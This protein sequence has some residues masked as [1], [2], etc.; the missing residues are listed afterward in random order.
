V[1]AEK[2]RPAGNVPPLSAKLMVPKPPLAVTGVNAVTGTFAGRLVDATASVVVS[3][4]ALT[5][6]LNVFDEFCAAGVVWS[7]AVTVKAVVPSRTLGVPVIWPVAVEKFK[8]VGN[9]PPLSAKLMVPKP[10]LAVTGV[11]GVAAVFAVKVIEGTACVVVSVSGLTV[12]LKVFDELC[13]AG[14][15]WSV[16]VTV[17]AVEASKT[18]GV[19]VI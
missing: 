5:V 18:L 17:K 9:V 6:R 2:L 13:A 10:P 16:A 7:V 1:V 4:A 11:T 19:P 8:P 12:R 15:V 14:V 3:V